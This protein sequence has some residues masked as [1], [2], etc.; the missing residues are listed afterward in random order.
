MTDAPATPQD[1]FTQWVGTAFGLGYAPMASGTFGAAPGALLAYGAAVASAHWAL[2]AQLAGQAL[3][4]LLLSVLAIP[5][6]DVSERLFGEKDDG[7]IVADEMLTFPV[8]TIGI[9]LLAAPWWMLGAFFVINRVSDI[10]KPAPARRLQDLHGGLGVVADDFVACL[11]ALAA[12]HAIYW[13]WRFWC[14]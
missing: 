12:N 10:V 7:R 11:Y 8:C 4:A 6:C 9:P 3:F 2:P 13:G 5:I 1:R 14:G